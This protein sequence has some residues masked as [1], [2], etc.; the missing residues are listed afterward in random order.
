VLWWY[1]TN[2]YHGGYITRIK[3]FLITGILINTGPVSLVLRQRRHAVISMGKKL[4]EA[5]RR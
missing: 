2:G 4:G 5:E 3:S 1:Q